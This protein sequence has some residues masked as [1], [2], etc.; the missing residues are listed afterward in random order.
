MRIS[1]GIGHKWQNYETYL[2][3]L[4]RRIQQGS[5][6]CELRLM[7]IGLCGLVSSIIPLCTGAHCSGRHPVRSTRSAAGQS[8]EAPA[9][10]GAEPRFLR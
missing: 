2:R 5:S 4:S 9:M 8:A 6:Q 10:R 3:S 7:E 1:I